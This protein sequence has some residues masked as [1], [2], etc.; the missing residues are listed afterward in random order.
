MSVRIRVLPFDEESCPSFW[1]SDAVGAT[2]EPER[3]QPAVRIATNRNVGISER[4][5][6]GLTNHATDGGPSPTPEPATDVDGSPFGGA[7]GLAWL[8][9]LFRL[10]RDTIELTAKT[11][12]TAVHGCH[13]SGTSKDCASKSPAKST[14]KTRATRQLMDSLSSRHIR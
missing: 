2:I 7:A 1:P 14:A 12:T 9:P 11:M 4:I 3:P 6:R 5:R 13:V 8:E 10:R